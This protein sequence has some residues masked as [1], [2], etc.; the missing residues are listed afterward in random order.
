MNFKL[1]STRS[2]IYKEY[3]M[4]K[5]NK[6]ENSLNKTINKIIEENCLNKTINKIIEEV[7]GCRKCNMTYHPFQK[8]SSNFSSNL[9]WCKIFI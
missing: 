8:K 9:S 6:E 4:K 3:E 7:K 2:G 1:D 5:Y